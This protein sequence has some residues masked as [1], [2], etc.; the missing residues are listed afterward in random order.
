MLS[1]E[2]DGGGG[3]DEFDEELV[4]IVSTESLLFCCFSSFFIWRAKL[5]DSEALRIL[6][7]GEKIT[8]ESGATLQ[9]SFSSAETKVKVS[10][11]RRTWEHN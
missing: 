7:A 2:E 1:G 5:R 6:V 4:D 9:L 8:G 3:V 11:T 10:W